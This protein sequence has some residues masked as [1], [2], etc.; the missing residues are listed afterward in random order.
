MWAV[1]YEFDAY[2]EVV[3]MACRPCCAGSLRHVFTVVQAGLDARPTL[4]PGKLFHMF[5]AGFRPGI[6]RRSPMDLQDRTEPRA[7]A[8]IGGRRNPDTIRRRPPDPDGTLG[9]GPSSGLDGL[10]ERAGRTASDCDAQADSG[11]AILRRG[12]LLD[13]ASV[14]A[15]LRVPAVPFSPH[16]VGQVRRLDRQ[17]TVACGMDRTERMGSESVQELQGQGARNPISDARTEGVFGAKDCAEGGARSA[18]RYAR[19]AAKDASASRIFA[20][21]RDRRN[22]EIGLRVERERRDRLEGNQSS[23]RTET[24]SHKV[25]NRP[26]EQEHSPSSLSQNRCQPVRRAPITRVSSRRNNRTIGAATNKVIANG[27]AGFLRNG[28]LAAQWD[29]NISRA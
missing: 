12:K 1:S 15:A 4:L 6:S 25:G 3:P 14:A 19:G 2:S 27:R 11:G 10:D 7:G 13:R 28:A 20:L 8:C 23:T 22:A 9:D 21:R 5:M 18:S 26:L 17:H 16:C 24:N 29:R